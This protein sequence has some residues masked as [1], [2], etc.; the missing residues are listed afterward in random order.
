[1]FFQEF[2]HLSFELAAV[3]TLKYLGISEKTNL[4]NVSNHGGYV[5]SLF[6][7]QRSG[8]FVSGYSI[9]SG[10]DILVLIPT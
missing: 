10:K 9:D 7:F 5:C 6:C 1:M 4:V 8:D 2:G 3:V